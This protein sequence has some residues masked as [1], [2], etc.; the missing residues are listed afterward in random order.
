MDAFVTAQNAAAFVDNCAVSDV[1]RVLR[2]E[3]LQLQ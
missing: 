3:N 1:R 2:R